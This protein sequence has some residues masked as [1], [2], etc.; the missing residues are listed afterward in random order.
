VEQLA[1]LSAQTSQEF[2]VIARDDGSR[3]GTVR[4]LS[5]HAATRPGRFTLIADGRTGLGAAG[6][7]AELARISAAPYVMFCDQD[8]VWHPDK[9]AI[10]LER[11]RLLEREHGAA[12]P[13]LV[14]GDLRVVDA[15]LNPIAPSFARY[16]RLPL[17]RAVDPVR[18]LV[19]NS[20]TGCTVLANRKLVELAL[21]LPTSGIMHDH[22]FALVA[23]VRGTVAALDRPLVD[24]RQHGRNVVGAAGMGPRGVWQRAIPGRQGCRQRLLA[25]SARAEALL[26]R[27]A[28]DLE[29]R[30]LAACQALA[31]LPRRGW[32]GRRLGIVSHRLWMAGWL[33]NL[34]WLALA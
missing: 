9:V 17:A 16:Q 25:A 27:C 34:A 12:T 28:E 31:T 18:L 19:Q 23:S 5:D 15:W 8:D 14:H 13:L 11:M 6:N 3:D 20:V 10:S 2:Q 4:I 1:S 21:P 26:A 24:Y 33:R 22:W 32:W 30:Q 7:F 29:P